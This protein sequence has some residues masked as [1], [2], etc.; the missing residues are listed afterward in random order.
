[1][2]KNSEHQLDECESKSYNFQDA[3]N[4]QYLNRPTSVNW[5]FVI[6]KSWAPWKNELGS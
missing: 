2:V 3:Y 5:T 1:M 6:E 4:E